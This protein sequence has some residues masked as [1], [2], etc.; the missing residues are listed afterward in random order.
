MTTSKSMFVIRGSMDFGGIDFCA[1]FHV[2]AQANV[3][4]YDADDVPVLA[5]TLGHQWHQR[6]RTEKCSNHLACFRLGAFGGCAFV[7]ACDP[8]WLWRALARCLICRVAGPDGHSRRFTV[9]I[10]ST[11]YKCSAAGVA[12]LQPGGFSYAPICQ[13]PG[14]KRASTKYSIL[15]TCLLAKLSLSL[16]GPFWEWHSMP[17]LET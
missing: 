14:Q 12:V 10:Y 5:S 2:S 17:G 6:C 13:R 7:L 3:L 11:V 15:L 8:V 9:Y 16:Q 4:Q 1:L